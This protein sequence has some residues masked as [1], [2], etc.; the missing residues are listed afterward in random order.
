MT[1]EI[2]AFE[3]ALGLYSVLIGLAIADI[4]GSVHRL[5]RRKESVRWDPLALLAAG[6]ALLISI[7][8]WFDLWGVR[9]FTATR[10]FFFYLCMIAV[11]F[12]VF[13]IAAASLPDDPE[14]ESDLQR[15]YLGNRRYFWLLVALFQLCYL[16][17][18]IYFVGGQLDRLPP[19][20]AATFAVQ[21]SVLFI[22]P[23]GL[24]A[25]TSRRAHYL[26]LVV[27]FAVNAWHY[28]PY[29]IV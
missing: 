5:A 25:T 10:H 12:L 22:V 11:L 24:A 16:W 3:F 9:D 8:M 18:G 26:G 29:A 15:F 4:A 2:R 28:A 21:M 19:A 17:F 7:G 6:Y 14:R 23:L 20:L 13:L 27:L 1:P